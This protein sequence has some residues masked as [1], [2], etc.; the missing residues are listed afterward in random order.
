MPAAAEWAEIVHR[1]VAVV[2]SAALRVLGCVSDAEDVAQ[3]V[4]LE[5]FR[6][7]DA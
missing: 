4:F 2:T 6:K 7:W 1:N 5:A 3:E